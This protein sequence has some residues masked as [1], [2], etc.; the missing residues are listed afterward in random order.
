M[1]ANGNEEVPQSH[2]RWRAIRHCRGMGKRSVSS[3]SY[4]VKSLVGRGGGNKN[5]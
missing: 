3:F 1:M 2:S 5:V 4:Y